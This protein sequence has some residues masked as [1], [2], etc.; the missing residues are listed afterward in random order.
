[1]IPSGSIP[2]GPPWSFELFER[3][4]FPLAGGTVR[5]SSVVRVSGGPVYAQNIHYWRRAHVSNTASG[6]KL[7]ASPLNHDYVTPETI[8]HRP[9]P[10]VVQI[11][12]R[13]R[14][15]GPRTRSAARSQHGVQLPPISQYVGQSG[16][17][18]HCL[19]IEPS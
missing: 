10:I 8:A 6:D 14:D 3:A 17:C 4:D 5:V 13:I 9:T 11:N 1:M 12:P 19:I 16:L 7:P 15:L 18:H 2:S